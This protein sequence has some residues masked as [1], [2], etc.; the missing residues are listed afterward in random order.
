MIFKKFDEWLSWS[1]SNDFGLCNKH[2]VLELGKRSCPRI[3]VFFAA[4]GSFVPKAVASFDMY[5]HFGSE[6]SFGLR[7]YTIPCIKYILAVVYKY[8]LPNE[9]LE[10]TGQLPHRFSSS[11]C[12]LLQS[13]KM[14]PNGR[15]SPVVAIYVTFF[16]VSYPRHN[17]YN[18]F[19]PLNPSISCTTCQ[20][21]GLCGS[22][23]KSNC[24]H[25]SIPVSAMLIQSC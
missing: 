6:N 17:E 21:K 5:F 23:A 12:L 25:I 7:F 22:F 16:I 11:Y 14:P 10:L 18:G 19:L 13:L 9:E 20:H 8:I 15:Q 4:D 1:L 2:A 24:M 3:Y